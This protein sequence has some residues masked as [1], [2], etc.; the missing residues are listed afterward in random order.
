MSLAVYQINEQGQPERLHVKVSLQTS[1]S[2]IKLYSETE[3]ITKLQVWIKLIVKDL[4]CIKTFHQSLQS[5][6]SPKIETHRP[7]N[8]YIDC[9]EYL[10]CCVTVN[11]FQHLRKLNWS[12]ITYTCILLSSNLWSSKDCHFRDLLN[13]INKTMSA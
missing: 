9:A 11:K 10:L 1:H 6:Y 2:N 8:W 3:G 12:G 13:C 5:N 4:L 7:M